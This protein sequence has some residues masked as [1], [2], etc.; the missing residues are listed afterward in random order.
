MPRLWSRLR[1]RPGPVSMVL[2]LRKPAS[3]HSE[4][5]SVAVEHA[6]GVSQI[7]EGSDSFVTQSG[8]KG[9]VYVKPHLISLLN[10]SRPYF[11]VDS[12]EHAKA[13]SQASQRKAW[14]EHEAWISL[15]YLRG[16]RDIELE[17]SV[18]ARLAAE[19]LDKNCCGLYIPRKTASYP[20]TLLCSVR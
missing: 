10:S 20:M 4:R 9:L 15:D 17:Y 7:A 16:G 6:W 12:N 2:L 8:D 1:N 14:S 19:M 3:L 5:L 11:D 18:L 13:L